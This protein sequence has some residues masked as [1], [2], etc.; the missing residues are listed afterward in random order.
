M[1][2]FNK[3]FLSG[4]E[5]NYISEAVNSGKLSGD[6]Q[7]TRKVHSWF[8]EKY[9]FDK[10][11]LTPSCTHALEMCA[12]AIDIKPGDQVIVPDYTFVSTANAFSNYGAQIVFA[13][14]RVDHPGIDEN[15]IEKLITSKT[16]AIVVVHYAGVAV[17][18]EKVQFLAKKYNLFLIEDAAQAID[19]HYYNGEKRLPLGSF[20]DFATFSFHD[21]K[22][23]ISGEGGL[24]VVN[25]SKYADKTDMIWEK[26]TNRKAFFDG[27]VDKYGWVSKGSSFLASEITAAFL[28]AQLENIDFIQNNRLEIWNKYFQKLGALDS[29]M[30]PYLP[31]YA[32]NNAHM[33]YIKT[34]S[35]VERRELINY[36]KSNGVTA[37]FHYLPLH[38]SDF[39]KNQSWNI[40]NDLSNSIRYASTLLRLPMYV[41]LGE[42][43]IEKICDLI[44]KFYQLK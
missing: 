3:V 44:I 4:P 27:M 36:L 24:L 13:D 34:R 38:Q 14:S 31:N 21:T 17:D 18:M 1:I 5:L 35:T 10:V 22:N 41:E 37:V 6:G 40:K 32:E 42:F 26:G 7:F 15:S 30:L 39:V 25:N 2:P 11:L 9:G 20:G 16:K 23:I 28:Y 8:K 43:E 12:M 19:S 33:F 29:E